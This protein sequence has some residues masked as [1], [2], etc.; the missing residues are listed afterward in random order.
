MRRS[1]VGSLVLGSLVAVACSAK[2]DTTPVTAGA[3]VVPADMRD[4]EREGE[5]LVTTT[6]GEY[7]ARTPD[8][9]RAASV[10]DLLK[11]VWGR[12][13]AATPGLP[14]AQVKAVDGAIAALDQALPAKDQQK[15][16]YAANAVG[17]A[18]P[19]LFDYFHPDAP[20]GVLRMDAVFRQVGLDGHYKNFA[21][22]KKDVDSLKSDWASTKG[23]VAQRVP[24]SH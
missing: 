14:A 13:K 16:V 11:Q 12:A 8:W 20:A 10:L 9:G 15:A 2:K 5:G 24:S 6:F 4:V 3:G 21:D 22:V 23:S 17:L 18:C 19:E 1:L 7:P